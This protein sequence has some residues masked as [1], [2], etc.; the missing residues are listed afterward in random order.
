[1]PTSDQHL[2]PSAPNAA[3]APREYGETVSCAAPPLGRK[4]IKFRYWLV[5]IVAG[6]AIWA[7]IAIALGVV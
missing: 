3:H 5:A 4:R 2:G 6:A 1:M 7:G